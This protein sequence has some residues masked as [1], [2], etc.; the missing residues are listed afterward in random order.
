MVKNIIAI[1][2]FI[3]IV[4]LTPGCGGKELN[5]DSFPGVDIHEII[6]FYPSS[7]KILQSYSLGQSTLPKIPSQC[8]C[9]GLGNFSGGGD[10]VIIFFGCYNS[11]K[12][13]LPSEK[14]INIGEI[15][16][17]ECFKNFKGEILDVLNQHSYAKKG[18]VK[19]PSSIT[20]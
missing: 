3:F 11:T 8:Q 18:F 19:S 13:L 10:K 2:L 1:F 9:I 20:D 17:C 5:I 12:K 16:R 7:G 6:Y 4:C 15:P 14:A